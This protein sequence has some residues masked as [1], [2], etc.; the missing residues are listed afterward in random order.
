MFASFRPTRALA[1]LLLIVLMV[2][3][4]CAV[5]AMIGVPLPVPSQLSASWRERRVPG[6]LV[7]RV[8]VAVF[9]VLWCWF[10]ATAIAEFGHVFRAQRSDGAAPL[11][12]L[13]AGPSG[14]VRSLVRL[15]AISSVSAT[16]AVG[17]LLPMI[18]STAAGVVRTPITAVTSAATRGVAASPIASPIAS[19]T[20]SRQPSTYVA[21]GRETPYSLASSFGRPE[22]RDRIIA[23]NSGRAAPD[24]T[25]WTNGVFPAGMEVLLPARE[26]APA[27]PPPQTTAPSFE[28][29][30]LSFAT[31]LGTALLLSAGAVSLLEA[32]RRR[33]WRAAGIGTRL[34]SPTPDDVRTETLLRS[35]TASE[36]VARLDVAVRAAAAD[37]AMQGAV[38][39]AAV[40]GD[41]GE[42]CLYL[43][44]EAHPTEPIWALDDATN[45]WRL[46]AEVDL[47]Q[48]ARSA[49]RVTQPCPAMVHLGS[50]AGGDVFVDL[51]AVGALTVVSPSSAPVLR[52][53][54][55][56]LALSPFMEVSR[57]FTVG[58][59][60]TWPGAPTTESVDSLDAA[61]DAAALTIGSTAAL[62]IPTFR[63]RSE[64]AG[65]E[66]WEPAIVVATGEHPTAEVAA[67]LQ[68]IGPG[69]GMGV[70]VD[71]PGL[72]GDWVLRHECGRHVL[73]PLGLE[74]HPVGLTAADVA[75]VRSVLAA[76]DKQ[77][78]VHAG[79]VPING[80][81]RS[82]DPFVEP[83]WSVMVRVLGQVEVVS[84]SGVVAAFDRSKALE[85]VVWLSQHRERPTRSA[86]RTALW[87]SDVRDATFANVVS[88][89]RRA[90]ARAVPPPVGEEWIA[91]TL[92]EDLPL[93]PGVCTDA[94]LLAARVAHASGLPA[95]EAI[96]V[97]RPGVELLGA[98]PFAGTS[99]LWTDAEGITS[100]LVLLATAAAIELANQYLTLG[101][102]E[103]VFWA[104]GQG[105][106][107][108]AGHEELIA[109]RMRAHARRGDLAGVRSEWESYER[110][111]AADPWA[112]AEPAA[113]LVALRRD[114]LVTQPTRERA[115]A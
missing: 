1:V 10:A 7:V 36:R 17:G 100:S 57:L 40:L 12:P 80:V 29:G 52:A 107:V 45:A 95:A 92:T 74:V 108:L 6:E 2:G 87:D 11:A 14:W 81:P 68:A 62:A 83:D 63:I 84:A 73:E 101:D 50:T 33:Q 32:R 44:G 113:K 85:L 115:L 39:V 77:P 42:V 69:R 25:V 72:P 91:R 71:R 16:V 89:A 106:K 67:V 114:L 64:A 88:D 102:I 66:A 8:G 37:L 22:M 104:T 78:V 96:E 30:A 70:V 4:P 61:V 28:S 21:A 49:R 59:D 93:H 48:L 112:S 23:L 86:A 105:L 3:V 58:L 65:G 24:G 35:L 9:A 111:L 38:V 47:A 13:S 46:A 43:R 53:I 41:S 82:A 99:Y 20:S 18:R 31:G 56:S 94:D 90:L 60:A 34:A 103:G 54:A 19:S 26:S 98:L 51:E 55:C 109:L 27:T 15:V 5:V 76:A 75:G 110:A 97:L 79:V